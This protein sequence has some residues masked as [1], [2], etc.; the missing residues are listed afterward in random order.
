MV[1]GL[2]CSRAR[3]VFLDHGSSQVALGV[4][5]LPAD[6]GGMRHRFSPWVGKIPCR[7]A[8]QPLQYYCLENP[9]D[10]GAWWATVHGVSKSLTRLS[11][12]WSDL[13]CTR[14]LLF[15][16]S[17]KPCSFPNFQYPRLAPQ[18]CLL[19]YP[20]IKCPLLPYQ[21]FIAKSLDCGFTGNT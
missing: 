20:F 1:H 21:S 11:I 3:G 5:N 10:R 18:L 12:F 2:S 8:W 19:K 16:G 9:M 17:L 7:R 14:K 4:K 15:P 6:A 13:A